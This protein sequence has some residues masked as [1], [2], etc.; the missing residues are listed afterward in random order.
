[1]HRCAIILGA[2]LLAGLGAPAKAR[3]DAP[4]LERTVTERPFEIVID[5]RLCGRAGVYIQVLGAGGPEA[6][7]EQASSGYLVWV[8]GRARVLV[9]AGPGVALRFDEAGADFNDL[10]AIV[11]TQLEVDHSSD[12][13]ALIRGSE[14]AGRTTPLPLYGPTGNDRVPGLNDWVSLLFG[15]TGAYRH[16][17]DYLSPLSA[18]GYEVVPY[19]I[20]AVG[21]RRWAGFRRDGIA[22]SAIP[23][24]HGQTP[25]LAWRVDAEGIGIT[26]TGDTANQ[27]QTVAE[28][29]KGSTILVASHAIPENTRGFARDLHMP[30]SQIGKMAAEA[31]VNFVILS[32]RS[33]RT[34]GREGQSRDII[35]EYF[36]GPI[37]FAN[38]LECWE[39]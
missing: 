35:Q 14:F 22:L 10:L 2:L 31:D 29:A 7:D 4:S 39:S 3:M 16:L 36:K 13:P 25:T 21:R 18:G 11:F 30:P 23:T 5:R 15:P 19:Q 20:D 26:F 17:S 6:G 8:D 28:L 9:D 32:H 1:M 33:P 12:L 27:R 34:R 38:D 24:D 37:L